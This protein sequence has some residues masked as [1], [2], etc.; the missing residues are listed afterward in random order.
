MIFS[1][2]QH[3]NWG[4]EEVEALIPWERDV[5]VELLKQHIEKQN[6]EAK[7]RLNNG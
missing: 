2:K 1:L 6:E 5:Y 4:V 3:H 7:K